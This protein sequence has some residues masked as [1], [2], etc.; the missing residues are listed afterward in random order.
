LLLPAPF[1]LGMAGLAGLAL[2]THP[3]SRKRL[4]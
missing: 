2:R 3:Q 1:W 4:L